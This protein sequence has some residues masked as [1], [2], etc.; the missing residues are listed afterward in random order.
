MKVIKAESLNEAENLIKQGMK[1]LKRGFLSQGHGLYLISQYDLWRFK[2][3]NSF[4]EY[5]DSEH[6]FKRSWAYSLMAV[7]VHFNDL[8]SQDESL[9]SIDVTRCVRLLPY[10]CEDES[11]KMELLHMAAHVPAKDFDANLRNMAGKKAVDQCE[12]HDFVIIKR[13]R[14]CGLKVKGD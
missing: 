6:T 10:I 13:C 5:L 9:Q 12:E 1:D 11:T 14:I 8:I 2:N 4:E 3:Y 7:Y